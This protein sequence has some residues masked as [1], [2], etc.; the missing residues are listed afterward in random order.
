MRQAMRRTI[1][2]GGAAFVAVG[3]A[4][5]LTLP[6]S[7]HDAKATPDCASNGQATVTIDATNYSLDGKNKTPNWVTVTDKDSGTV[8]LDKTFFGTDFNIKVFPKIDPVKLDGTKAHTVTVHVD[9]FDD[10]QGKKNFTK[11]I[12]VSTTVCTTSGGG[13]STTQP[14][15]TTTPSPTSKPAAT[16]T[17]A[18][19]GASGSGQ[20]PNTGVSTAVPLLVAGV[21]VV[22]GGGILLWLRLG[23]KRR[24]TDS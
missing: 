14:P 18:L 16:T 19:A 21:L 15:T 7:A 3:A 22:A 4:L 13:S 24:R 1:G 20:L 9:A 23:A 17:A 5:V 6:A 8:L 2:L 12:T 10:P 11:D